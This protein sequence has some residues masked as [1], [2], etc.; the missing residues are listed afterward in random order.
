[1]YKREIDNLINQN[2]IPKNIMLFGECNYFI[3]YYSNIIV[4]NIENNSEKLVFYFDEYDFKTAKN[5]LSQTSLFGDKNILILKLDKK[6]SKDEIKSLIDLTKKVDDSYL[7]VEFY[8]KDFKTMSGYFK[9][10]FVRFFKPFLNEAI[11]LLNIKANKLNI[12][13]DRYSLE[14]LLVIEN[15]DLALAMNE[16]NKFAILDIKITTKEID[17]LTYG[18]GDVNLDELILKIFDKK[19]FFSDLKTILEKEDELRVIMAIT[20]FISNIF[21]FYLFFQAN[22]FFDSKAVLG[23][24]LPKHIEENRFKIAKRLN[25][26][27]FDLIIEHLQKSELLLKTESKVDKNSILYSTLIKLQTLF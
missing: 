8:G 12:D 3:E 1:M 15:Y 25:L 17:K 16:L 11:Q 13:I 2:K 6:I 4:K 18:L 7:I 5:Y 27:S 26:K 20:S 19:Y 10:S 24:K 9:N 23:Y 14:H 21:M 22:G